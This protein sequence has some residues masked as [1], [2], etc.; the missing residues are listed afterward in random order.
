[1]ADITLVAEA[2]RPTGSAVSAAPPQR[3]SR[4]GLRPR[5]EPT[6]VTVARRSC[7]MR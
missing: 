2:G 3:E 7:A 6:A 5:A 4:G 1:M